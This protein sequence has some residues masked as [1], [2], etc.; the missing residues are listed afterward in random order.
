MSDHEKVF[1]V[2]ENKCFVEVRPKED[3][4][5]KEDTYTKEETYSKEESYSKSEVYK[6]SEVYSKSETDNKFIVKTDV[7]AK[8]NFAEV[9]LTAT[10]PNTQTEIDLLFDLPSGF[11]IDNCH[12]IGVTHQWGQ[13]TAYGGVT[14][15]D[16]NPM[17]G[18]DH[19][20][21]IYN[22]GSGFTVTIYRDYIPSH[23]V[24]LLFM[25][26]R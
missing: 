14:F 10:I 25:K 17:N 23:K 18:G 1:G 8:G 5:S 15:G 12:L 21:K 16:T 24:K 26:I 19:G 6:K 9:V 11:T 7:Y 4:Y 22:N 3:T 2:C 13:S 20:I